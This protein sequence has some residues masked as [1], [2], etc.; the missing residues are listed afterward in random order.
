MGNGASLLSVSNL[1]RQ[2]SKSQGKENDIDDENPPDREGGNM[3]RRVKEVNDRMKEVREEMNQLEEELNGLGFAEENM[4]PISR[5]TPTRTRRTSLN[6]RWVEGYWAFTKYL[7]RIVKL[8]ALKEKKRQEE[9]ERK[10]K[11]LETPA[12]KPGNISTSPGSTTEMMRRQLQTITKLKEE[13]D[14]KK[15]AKG[16][17]LEGIY[18]ETTGKYILILNGSAEM[19][20]AAHIFFLSLLTQLPKAQ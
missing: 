9:K 2:R 12:E 7:Y 11:L 18:L 15:R 20:L 14:K 3:K 5:S 8:V 1:H 17:T 13:A 6:G 19:K 4:E 10:N 16:R